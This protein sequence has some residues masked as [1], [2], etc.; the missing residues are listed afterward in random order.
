MPDK[1]SYEQSRVDW[2]RLRAYPRRV[3]QQTRLPLRGPATYSSPTEQT[4]YRTETRRAG[5]LGRR[6]ETIKVP[7]II[8]TALEV[9]ALGR[10]W[11]LANRTRNRRETTM[12]GS[13]VAAETSEYASYTYALTPDGELIKLV[14]VREEQLYH[15]LSNSEHHEQ[16]HHSAEP[17]SDSDVESFDFDH[18]FFDQTQKYDRGKIQAWGDSHNPHGH[19]LLRH[20]KGVG[21]TLVLKELLEGRLPQ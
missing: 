13:R 16:I 4:T 9:E 18:S 11:L 12:D 6:L 15:H 5:F 2:P 7:E 3:S 10:H 21:L 1:Q 14:L 8:S 17:F 19:R 20:A